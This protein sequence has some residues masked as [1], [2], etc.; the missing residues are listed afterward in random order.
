MEFSSALA[1]IHSYNDGFV[2]RSLDCVRAGFWYGVPCIGEGFFCQISVKKKWEEESEKKHVSASIGQGEWPCTPRTGGDRYQVLDLHC[3]LNHCDRLSKKS[4]FLDA[5][6]SYF[7][8][9]FAF[10][11]GKASFVCSQ[12]NNILFFLFF[13]QWMRLY[14]SLCVKKRRRTSDKGLPERVT[15]FTSS[16][17]LN[18]FLFCVCVCVCVS[19]KDER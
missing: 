2:V 5:C 18:F 13:Y 9:C 10:N 11:L 4:Q 16:F 19:K 6:R 8:Q 17:F 12:A 3:W 7:C 15:E 14:L 1:H